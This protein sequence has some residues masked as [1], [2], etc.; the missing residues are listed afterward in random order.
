MAYV[1]CVCNSTGRSEIWDKFHELQAGVKFGINF[2]S[3]RENGNFA[4][5]AMSG[6]YPKI[7]LLLVL[8]QINTVASFIKVKISSN[9]LPRCVVAFC[10][11]CNSGE[12]R[13]VQCVTFQLSTG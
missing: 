1:I 3:C 6:I 8:S 2:T 4:I 12:T 5:L 7:S 13:C 9:S 11:S 10:C